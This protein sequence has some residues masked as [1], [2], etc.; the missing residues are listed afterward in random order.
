MGFPNRINSAVKKIRQVYDEK[1]SEHVI[2]RH[3]ECA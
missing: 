2:Y 1:K 3:T